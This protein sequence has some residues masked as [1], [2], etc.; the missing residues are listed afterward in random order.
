MDLVLRISENDIGEF[1]GLAYDFCDNKALD[2]YLNVYLTNSN[3]H[4]FQICSAGFLFLH[5]ICYIVEKISQHNR[6]WENNM[7]VRVDRDDD[8]EPL[9]YWVCFFKS[10]EEENGTESDTK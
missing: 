2:E 9:R 8:G 5:Q 10:E 4:A 3:F 7:F 6:N 1:N